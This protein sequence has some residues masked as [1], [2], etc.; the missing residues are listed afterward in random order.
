LNLDTQLIVFVKAPRAGTVKTRLAKAMGEAAACAAYRR[1]VEVVLN[2]LSGLPL[3]L[4]YTPDDAAP[5]IQPWLRTGWQACPQGEGD[6]GARLQ[7]ACDQHFS[8]GAKAVVIIGSDCP[9][10][11]RDDIRE[12]S[13]LLRKSDLVL[14]PA[15]DGGYWLIGLRQPQPALFEGIRWGTEEVLAQTLE[16]ARNASLKIQL[17][18]IL[19]DVDTQKDWNEFV[20]SSRTMPAG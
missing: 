2:N 17:L 18:R 6:L 9:H 15:T 4:R 14:G 20:N 3:E 5:E 10:V 8:A 1:L 16:R 7:G 19:S 11:T 12:A 13:R